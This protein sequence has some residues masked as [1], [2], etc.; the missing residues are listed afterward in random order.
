M[1][2]Y[3]MNSYNEKH[4]IKLGFYRNDGWFE[5]KFPCFWYGNKPTI[6]GYIR[7]LPEEKEIRFDVRLSNGDLYA[8]FYYDRYGNY[9]EM[10]AIIDA[11]F[12]RQKKKLGIKT[13]KEKI[14]RGK[15]KIKSNIRGRKQQINK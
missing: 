14:F 15:E 11:A 12:N 6:F 3:Y 8:P 13:K 4:L 2:K 1:S 7:V 9:T 5:Y 10:L